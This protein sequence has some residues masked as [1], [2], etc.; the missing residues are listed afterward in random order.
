MRAKRGTPKGC[1]KTR[2]IERRFWNITGNIIKRKEMILDKD[3]FIGVHELDGAGRTGIA[4]KK[5]RI[6]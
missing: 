5:Y 1:R 3:D 2:S 6:G 4:C